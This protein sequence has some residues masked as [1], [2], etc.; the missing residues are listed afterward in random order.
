MH[1]KKFQVVLGVAISWDKWMVFYHMKN[2]LMVVKKMNNVY[3]MWWLIFLCQGS[4]L[5]SCGN[6]WYHQVS[7]QSLFQFSIL[8]LQFFRQV[9]CWSSSYQVMIQIMWQFYKYD[10]LG[11]LFLMKTCL[12]FILDICCLLKGA[13][14]LIWY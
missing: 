13:V 10:S 1:G 14:F 8:L 5:C 6:I 7:F 4:R 3:L 12:F 2:F 11:K 9:C